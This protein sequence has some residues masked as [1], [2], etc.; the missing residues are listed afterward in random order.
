MPYKMNTILWE[1]AQ[2]SLL[3]YKS[4]FHQQHYVLF[5]GRMIGIGAEQRVQTAPALHEFTY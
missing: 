1:D 4:R 3:G 2:Y 5:I